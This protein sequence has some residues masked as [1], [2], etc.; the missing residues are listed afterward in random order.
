MKPTLL[1]GLALTVLA[2]A[3]T[4]ADARHRHFR[5]HSWGRAPSV[6]MA[7]TPYDGAPTHYAATY[8]EAPSKLLGAELDAKGERQVSNRT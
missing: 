8:S 6:T 7:P 1:V 4:P 5:F 3:A 2:L